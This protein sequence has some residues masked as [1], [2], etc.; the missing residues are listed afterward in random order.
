MLG[1]KIHEDR[2]ITFDYDV[3]VQAH[4]NHLYKDQFKVAREHT[5][6]YCVYIRFEGKQEHLQ[7]A[8]SKLDL[9]FYENE[10]ETNGIVYTIHISNNPEHMVV[11]IFKPV[12]R[13]ATL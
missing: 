9:Y 2:S 13:H 1:T 4:N 8:H 12:L 10:L 5:C 11:D 3:I 7:Y 6:D